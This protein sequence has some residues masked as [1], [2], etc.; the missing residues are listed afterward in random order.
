[1][2]GALLSKSLIQFSVDGLGC[3]PSLLSD[4]RPNYGGGNEDN[5]DLLQKVPCTSCCTRASI[6][7]KTQLISKFGVSP[8]P[9]HFK[10]FEWLKLLQWYIL[11]LGQ[12]QLYG[13]LGTP[14]KTWQWRWAWGPNHP[15]ILQGVRTIQKGLLGRRLSR[16]ALQPLALIIG[17]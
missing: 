13:Y 15:D 2:G 6:T 11:F 17:K 9:Q 8:S 10:P 12:G 14:D 4:L 7:V 3:I 1:M 16:W 5:G